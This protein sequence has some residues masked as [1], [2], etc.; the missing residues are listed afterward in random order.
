LLTVALRAAGLHEE[1]AVYIFLTLNE[2]VARSVDRVFDLVKLFRTLPRAAARDIL[3]AVL[4]WTPQDRAG[5]ASAYQPYH[6]PDAQRP[7]MQAA[8]TERPS[9][10]TP[11]PARQRQ[12]S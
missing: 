2:T 11:L 3:A 4:D 7:R 12:T 6:T 10:R 5:A 8:V 9:L 1:E